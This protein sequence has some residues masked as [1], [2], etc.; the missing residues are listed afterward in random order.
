LAEEACLRFDHAELAKLPQGL[1]VA[2]E[3][4]GIEARPTADVER[5]VAERD[6]SRADHLY[7][8]GLREGHH[9]DIVE[10][11]VGVLRLC[12]RP[13]REGTYDIVA[14][15]HHQVIALGKDH[16]A[17]WRPDLA[18]NV[19]YCV[20]VTGERS[21]TG[22]QLRDDGPYQRSSWRVPLDLRLGGAGRLPLMLSERDRAHDTAKK[23]TPLH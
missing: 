17:R 12:L 11:K 6:G 2:H 20:R 7:T 14:E 15:H 1:R 5:E 21:N 16:Q 22:P 19:R 10:M 13:C 18:N 3:D 9:H 4:I 8:H 23:C